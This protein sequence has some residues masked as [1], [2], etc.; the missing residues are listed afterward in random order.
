MI[1]KFGASLILLTVVFVFF[2]KG[3][4]KVYAE[5]T[6]SR[7]QVLREHHRLLHQMLNVMKDNVDATQKIME[8]KLSVSGRKAMKKKLADMVGEVEDMIQKH[9]SLMKSFEEMTQKQES[10]PDKGIEEIP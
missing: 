6:I 4:G 7:S 10:K 9:D 5:E 1:L 3:V 2:A 8:G